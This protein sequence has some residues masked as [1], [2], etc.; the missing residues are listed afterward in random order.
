MHRCPAC[1]HAI[2]VDDAFV[3][4]LKATVEREKNRPVLAL[5]NE[6]I[7]GKYSPPDPGDE[8]E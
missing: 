2:I 6:I 4:A 8:D 3:Q 5:W 7:S 1:G